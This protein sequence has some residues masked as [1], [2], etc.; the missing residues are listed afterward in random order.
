MEPKAGMDVTVILFP[1]RHI[2]MEAPT[3]KWNIPL[4][5]EQAGIRLFQVPRALHTPGQFR[6]LPLH[7]RS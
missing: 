5:M 7:R 2:N 6:I 1:G 4:T 3:G